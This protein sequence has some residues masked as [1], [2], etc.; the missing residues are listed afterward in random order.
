MTF[1]LVTFPWVD[2]EEFRN[3]YKELYSHDIFLQQHAVDRIAAWEARSL[4][5]LPIAVEST[6]AF[7]KANIAYVSTS[8]PVG[9]DQRLREIY[10]MAVIRFVNLF[11]ERNQQKPHALPV[12]L[13]ASYLG[14]PNWIVDLRHES[15]H[16]ALPSLTEFRA[17]AAW[18]LEWLKSQFWDVQSIETFR[19][20]EQKTKLAESLRDALVTFMQRKFQDLTNDSSTISKTL[21]SKIDDIISELGVSCFAVLLE[22]G[23]MVFTDEQL[24]SIDIDQ[25]DVYETVSPHQNCLP[26]IVIDFWKPILLILQRCNLI[27]DFLLNISFLL[28]L[29]NSRRTIFLSKWFYTILFLSNASASKKVDT[30]KL[31]ADLPYRTLLNHCLL[32]DFPLAAPCIQVLFKCLKMNKDQVSALSKLQAL[33][34][35]DEELPVANIN[36]VQI[37]NV[38]ELRQCVYQAQNKWKKVQ[39]ITDWSRIPFGCLPDHE[40]TYTSLE[41]HKDSVK[42]ITGPADDDIYLESDSDIGCENDTFEMDTIDV[43]PSEFSPKWD[44]PVAIIAEDIELY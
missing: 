38:E 17:A 14:V 33:R 5:R 41:L 26:K 6:A 44:K 10:S 36:D 35:V 8:Q 39:K 25:E 11:T 43:L 15:T 37:H 31:T 30:F 22:D 9:N 13:A 27:A 23:Y 29:N 16:A 1:P 19:V 18:C 40:L 28:S 7:I 12:H 20:E 3:V 21:V 2:R 42:E 32:I 24:S 4:S 34:D